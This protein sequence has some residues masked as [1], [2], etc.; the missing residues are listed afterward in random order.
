MR[1]M[2]HLVFL[3]TDYWAVFEKIV[4]VSKFLAGRRM[5]WGR[6]AAGMELVGPQS[7]S[8]YNSLKG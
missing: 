8:K 6:T 4:S 7:D 3:A 5:Q 2:Q 1:A